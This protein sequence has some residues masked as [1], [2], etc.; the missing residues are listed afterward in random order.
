M[1]LH[2]PLFENPAF[3]ADFERLR[4][5]SLNPAR[6]TSGNAHEHSLRVATRALSLAAANGCSLPQ[7]S[8]LRDLGLVH[9]IGKAEGTSSPAKSMELLPRYGLVDPSFVELVRYHDINL[10][11]HISVRKGEPPSDKAWRKMA[12]RVDVH[13]LCLFMVAD[14]VDCPGGWRENAALV[15]FLA[16]ATRRDL[17]A[18]S[19]EL[20]VSAREENCAGVALLREQAG[21]T[22][23]L[24]VRVRQDTW[25]LPKGHVEEDES[26][27][28]A[29]VRELIEET[30]LRSP[31]PPSLRYLD[32]LGYEVERSGAGIRKHVTYFTGSVQ[33]EVT[34]DRPSRTKELRW[35]GEDEARALS[36]PSD[37]LRRI[38]LGA[39]RVP[40]G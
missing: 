34:F 7:T 32:S 28:Q 29:A 14:R 6:H 19:L 24:I 16:E 13:L 18:A 36:L 5:V 35:I 33:G 8:V 23:L 37:D 20:D 12:A 11:W 2:S 38:V 30:G 4:A 9:D 39:L 27:E 1:N 21:R 31:A 10:P 22:E 15:W 40:H 17:L 26:Q 25:E 3:R